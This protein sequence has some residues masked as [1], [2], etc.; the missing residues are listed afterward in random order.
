TADNDK[1]NS[2]NLSLKQATDTFTQ[3]LISQQLEQHEFNWA[4]TARTLQ[5]DRAN[6]VRLAK[7][8]GIAV[9]KT[10]VI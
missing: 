10:C 5:V 6:L 4:A 9:K 1:I 3:H 7:R 8:L 2:Q